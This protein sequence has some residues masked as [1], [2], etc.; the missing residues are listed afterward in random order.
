MEHAPLTFA[1][2]TVAVPDLDAAVD[3]YTSTAGMRL[4]SQSD[5]VA[6]FHVGPEDHCLRVNGTGDSAV[7]S[8]A[9]GASPDYVEFAVTHLERIG[10]DWTDCSV[11]GAEQGIAFDDPD[12]NRIELIVDP[13]QRAAP[14]PT[15][16][17]PAKLLHPLL[18]VGNLDGSVEF[19]VGL[20]FRISDR[21]REKAAFLR[22]RDGFHHSLALQQSD[23]LPSVDHLCFLISDFDVLMRLRARIRDHGGML[24][25]DIVRHGGSES[26]SFYFADPHSGVSFEYCTGHRQ[27]WDDHHPYRMLPAEPQ[28]FDMWQRY[29]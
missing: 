25:G 16:V 10:H 18:N 15:D 9:Y 5:A 4:T 21:I 17:R 23:G 8:L 1:R 22:C 6:T 19:Y 24:D 27:I 20:G 28:T 26:I 11:A 14:P 7:Q 3:F 2:A 29:Q 13:L 12:A